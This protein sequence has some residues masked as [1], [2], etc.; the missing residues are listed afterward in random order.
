MDFSCLPFAFS[1][2]WATKIEHQVGVVVAR[3]VLEVVRS[4][5][6]YFLLVVVP[7]KA[8]LALSD[9]D[10]TLSKTGSI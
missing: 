4:H 10:N 8:R 5:F 6:W 3:Q 2:F 9:N 1:P 7:L